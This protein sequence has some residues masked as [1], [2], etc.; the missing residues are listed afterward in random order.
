MSKR[1]ALLFA[2]MCLMG[3][4]PKDITLTVTPTRSFKF[5]DNVRYAVRIEPNDDNREYCVGYTGDAEQTSC[6]PL[7]GANER[8]T[9]EQTWRNVPS[10]SYTAWAELRRINGTVNANIVRFEIGVTE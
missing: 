1:F 5:E 2:C 6:Y 4:G 7:N 8:P 3:A 10:G 9:K